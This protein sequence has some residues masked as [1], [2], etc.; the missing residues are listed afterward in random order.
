MTQ[1]Q[2]HDKGRKFVEIGVKTQSL[3]TILKRILKA[4]DKNS[5]EK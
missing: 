2:I 1:S 5:Q 3:I 4:I